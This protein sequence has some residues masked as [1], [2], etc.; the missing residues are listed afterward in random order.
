MTHAQKFSVSMPPDALQWVQERVAE[1]GSVSAVLTAL[2]REAQAAEESR[3]VRLAAFDALLA[4]LLDEP[5]RAEE[6]QAG[7]DELRTLGVL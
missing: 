5:L 7:E 3:A 6:L 1:G 4:E 2:V